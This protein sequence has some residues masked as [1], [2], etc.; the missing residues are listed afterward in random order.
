MSASSVSRCELTDTYSPVAIDIAPAATPARPATM[1]ALLPAL[2]A[3]TPIMML[4]TETMPSSAP[5][6]AA[7]N[8][9]TRRN[10]WRSRCTIVISSSFA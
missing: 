2:D 9:P 3:E 1:M 10:R 7:R 8:H 5:S 6:T 4:A